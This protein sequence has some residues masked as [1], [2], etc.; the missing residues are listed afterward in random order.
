[1]SVSVSVLLY[2]YH[3]LT[4][5]SSSSLIH[6]CLP[7]WCNATCRVH[8]EGE[9]ESEELL[10]LAKLKTQAE[11]A[12][13]GLYDE[14]DP[15]AEEE[16]EKAAYDARPSHGHDVPTPSRV[17]GDAE[18]G[19]LIDRAVLRERASSLSKGPSLLSSRS[20]RSGSGGHSHRLP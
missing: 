17:R 12:T 2:H 16:Y 13:G 9:L 4:H 19:S 6:S 3:S 20:A 11:A 10:S 8:S 1:V 18:V 7:A 15:E 14:M 5:S